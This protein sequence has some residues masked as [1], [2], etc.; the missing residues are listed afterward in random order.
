M[1]EA[2]RLSVENVA[3][4][5][6]GPFGAVVVRDGKIIATGT[7]RVTTDNDPTAHAEMVA[8]RNA[9]AVL[10]TF[11]LDDCDIYSSCEPC[12]MCLSAIYW[13]RPRALYYANTKED[14]ALIN[15]DDHF[16]YDEI[17][18]PLLE[19][20]IFTQQY[21]RNEALEAFRLWEKSPDKIDY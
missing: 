19:R 12:P 5:I 3:E 13:A 15:F 4:R 20:N 10:G 6:G 1:E 21:M 11:Q 18:K 2:I 16:I 7:N 14:A 9:C 17:A 8:I